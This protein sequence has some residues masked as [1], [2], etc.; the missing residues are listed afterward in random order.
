MTKKITLTLL[1]NVL[2]VSSL[3]SQIKNIEFS[4][5]AYHTNA[6]NNNWRWLSA[7][8]T[9]TPKKNWEYGLGLGY[10]I[11]PTFIKESLFYSTHGSTPY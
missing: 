10:N 9:Y 8:F 4:Q 6:N 3:F 11:T 5:Y 7:T 2:I 1:I